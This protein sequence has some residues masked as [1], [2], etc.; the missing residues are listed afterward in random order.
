MA[1]LAGSNAVANLNGN[2]KEI[3]SDKMERLIP[4]GKKIL[5][6][7]KFMSKDRQ[8]GNAYHQP[9]GH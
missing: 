6:R 1:D 7:I 4:D 5:Q 9:C 3:Y 2:F 8:P